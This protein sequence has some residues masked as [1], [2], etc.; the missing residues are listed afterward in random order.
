MKTLHASTWQ[1]FV[2]VKFPNALPS[3]FT[4]LIVGGIFSV[5]TAVGAEFVGGATG[6]GNRIMYFSQLIQTPKIY[7]CI[8]TLSLMGISIY[9]VIYGVSLKLTA[10]RE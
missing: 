3:V 5:I 6:L 8:F 2:K 4:G 10:W 9:L 7:A 1:T